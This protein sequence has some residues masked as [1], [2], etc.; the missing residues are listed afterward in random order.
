MVKWHNLEFATNLTVEDFA[1]YR[2]WEAWGGTKKEAIYKYFDFMNSEYYRQVKPLSHAYEIL[3][4]LQNRGHILLNIT[5]RQTE[6]EEISLRQ[7]EEHF[8]GIFEMTLFGNH[9]SPTDNQSLSKLELCQENNV[10]ILIDDDPR[11]VYPCIGRISTILFGKYP[12]NRGFKTF[13]RAPNWFFVEPIINTI[14]YE[15]API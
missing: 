4:R 12:W 3:R 14:S 7:L 10:H 9:Y 11:N 6:L 1:T 8:P 15:P 5:A 2:F 13:N